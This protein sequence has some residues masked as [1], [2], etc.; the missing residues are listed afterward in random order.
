MSIPASQLATV[1]P[2]VL[3]AGGSAVDMNG[4]IL[5]GSTYMPSGKVMPFAS[6]DDVGDF[7]GSDS[8][9]KSLADIYFKG[10]TNCTKYPASLL[11]SLWP[12]VATAA[13][14]TG[15]S[16]AGVSVDDMKLF[17][18]TFS[19]TVDGTAVTA[20]D[21]DFSAITSYSDAADVIAEAVGTVT[22]VYDSTKQG[23][24]LTSKTT[25]TA[26]TI[27]AATGTLAGSLKLSQDSGAIASQGVGVVTP[28][29]TMDQIVGIAPNWGVFT[30][31]VEPDLEQKIEFSEWV[32]GRNYEYAYVGWDTDP[33]AQQ[34]NAADSFGAQVKA[35]KYEGVFP[36]WGSAKTAVFSMAIAA[37]LDFNR[38]NGRTTWAYRTQS[39]LVSEVDDGT[40]AANLLSNGYNYFGVYANKKTTWNILFNG[41]VAG[42][43]KWMDSFINQI[44]LNAN[45]QQAMIDLLTAVG[46][47]P[48]ATDGYTMV[49]SSCMDP[50]GKALNFGAIRTG[51]T[52]SESQKAQIIQAVG[53]DVTSSI[54][55]KGYYLQIVEA[56]ADIRSERASPPMTLY[57]ADGGSIQQLTLASIEIQ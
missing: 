27:T 25:G 47:I 11:F 53:S 57:Y 10:F 32:N 43:F 20:D 34:P 26:S 1:V 49:E 51:T 29:K 18:G 22:A 14:L 15:G 12:Q 21:M 55:N 36:L 4:L 37:S 6:A 30:T 17:T 24:V 46:S 48:Y 8:L 39:G 41:A 16:L 44:W 2:G 13:M 45:L 19:I 50:I 23:F 52:I 3:T 56:T 38:R 54:I 9:E 33:A 7:F 40:V 42:S 31:T 28:K 5:T 35:N